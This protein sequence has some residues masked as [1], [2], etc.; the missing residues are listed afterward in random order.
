MRKQYLC[1]EW[2]DNKAVVDF[3]GPNSCNIT[4]EKEKNSL[5][6]CVKGND[7]RATILGELSIEVPKAVIDEV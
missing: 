5:Y 7:D 2:P 6:I 3:L 4:I 1:I